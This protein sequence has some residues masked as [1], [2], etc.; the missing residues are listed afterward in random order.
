MILD[1]KEGYKN[2]GEKMKFSLQIKYKSSLREQNIVIFLQ[3][4]T[5]KCYYQITI[6]EIISWKC[7]V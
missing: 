4:K 6:A 3:A 5:K 1:Y 2:F 7:S